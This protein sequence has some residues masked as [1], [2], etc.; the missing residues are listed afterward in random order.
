MQSH[1]LKF[2][3]FDSGKRDKVWGEWK[4]DVKYNS[5]HSTMLMENAVR[6][7]KISQ[8][9]T[10]LPWLFSKRLLISCYIFWQQSIFQSKCC[11]VIYVNRPIIKKGLPIW[12]YIKNSMN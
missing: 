11:K 8:K 4:F 5:I 2:I 10:F 12:R 9:S 6:K 1:D 7:F 3:M